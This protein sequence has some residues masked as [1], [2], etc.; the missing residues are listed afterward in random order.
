MWLKKLKL[1]DHNLY[2]LATRKGGFNYYINQYCFYC[3]S[4]KQRLK[5]FV[6]PARLWRLPIFPSFSIIFK[7]KGEIRG[8]NVEFFLLIF[9][10]F[11]GRY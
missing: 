6:I 11:R 10:L 7:E 4:K 5:K 2:K 1:K 8:I 3:L 9:L